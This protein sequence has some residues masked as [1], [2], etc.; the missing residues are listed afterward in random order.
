MNRDQEI[1]DKIDTLTDAVVLMD[2]AI[3]GPRDASAPGLVQKMA[4]LASRLS[5]IEKGA[6]GTG[7][8]ALMIGF[9]WA[10]LKTGG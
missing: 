1:I 10:W 3:R 6:A 9:G 8:G 5:R 7:F 2:D 4:V